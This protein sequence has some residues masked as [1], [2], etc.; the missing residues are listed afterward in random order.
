MTF[1][2]IIAINLSLVSARFKVVWVV[3]KPLKWM[4][5][6][7]KHRKVLIF[8]RIKFKMILKGFLIKEIK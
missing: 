8:Q 6:I 3:I 4:K 1:K 7:K 2:R 5:K